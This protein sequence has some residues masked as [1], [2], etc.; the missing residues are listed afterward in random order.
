[1]SQLKQLI[2]E[3]HRRSL[4]QVLAIYIVASWAVLEAADVIVARFS[5][6]DW[7]YGAAIML[8]LVGLPIVVAT[9]FVQEGFTTKSMHDPTLMP[10][11]ELEADSGP[12][13]VVGAR[14]L[15]SWRNAISG[16]VLALALWGVV[17]TGWIVLYGGAT[18]ESPEQAK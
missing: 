15:F 17:A 10:G 1:M 16:G 11:G 14:R 8:L 2:T 7:V 6:P 3:I 5:L 9:A 12:R 18:A 13:E 4:W